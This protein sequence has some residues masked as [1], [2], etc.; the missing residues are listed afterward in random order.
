MVLMS[1]RNTKRP[2]EAG[3]QAAKLACRPHSDGP[4]LAFS[5]A[6]SISAVEPGVPRS[7]R[8]LLLGPLIANDGVP[9]KPKFWACSV[10]FVTSLV[11]FAP[12]R[13][14]FHLAM[15]LTPAALATAVRNSS[16]A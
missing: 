15:Y 9:V 8:P 11:N 6:S 14:S 10:V 16:V 4:Q 1:T 13:S 3:R 12:L 5:I 7:S 2:A